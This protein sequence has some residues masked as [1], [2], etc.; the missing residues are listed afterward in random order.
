MKKYMVLLIIVVLRFYVS[1][2]AEENQD[3][4]TCVGQFLKI[5][6]GA[7]ACGMGEAFCAVADDVNAIYWNP[8][9][10]GQ[11]KGKE[12]T[13]MH[14]EWLYDLKYEF[15]AYCQPFQRGVNAIS[16]TY[17]RMGDLEGKD[18]D[19]NP[20]GNFAAYDY[21]VSIAYSIPANEDVYV[22]IA[23]K[24]IHQKIEKEDANG[25]AIDIGVLYSD[26]L[27]KG[28]K[29]AVVL[30]NLGTK[31][32]FVQERENLPL[33][34]KLGV[35]YKK[36]KLILAGDITKPKD[37]DTR[38]NLG[39]EY[40][41]TSILALRVGYNSKNDLDSGWTFGAGF[42]LEALQID[43]AFVPYGKLDDTH[44]FSLTTRF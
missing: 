19:D 32:K 20:I 12:A 42:K 16:I 5:G 2:Y 29:T 34:Y 22:G 7:R 1:V 36:D 17:L 31:L 39:A 4:G 44:R 13:F 30:Q 10:L 6:A 8:A 35:S 23:G 26:P 15:L 28:F 9:G 27:K 14:N 33:T 41:P 3:A 43:Y 38:V 37:N 21:A 11:I 24:F 25:T 18:K 40:L